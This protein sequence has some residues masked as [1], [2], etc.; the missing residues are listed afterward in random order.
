MMKHRLISWLLLIISLTLTIG[1]I[2]SWFSLGQ[3]GDIIKQAEEKLQE[4]EEK[5]RELKRQLAQVESPA[6]IEK[7]AR[8]KLNLGKEGETALILP[9]ISPIARPTPTTPDKSSNWEKW[10]KLFY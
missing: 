3:Q 5:Q 2:R 10:L 9:S 4:E 7:E 8:N 1:V 6:Y